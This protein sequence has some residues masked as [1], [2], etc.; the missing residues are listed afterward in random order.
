MTPPVGDG[1]RYDALAREGAEAVRTG[2]FARALEA[3]ASAAAEARRMSDCAR[4]DAADLNVAMALL[5]SG[6][7]RRAEDGLREILLRARTDQ[8]AF[9][10]AY[11]LASSLRK[12]GRY[13]RALDYA[14]RALD[15][16]R[17]LGG[18][19]YLAPAHNL[20]GNILLCRNA[21]DEAERS[22]LEALALREAQRSDTRF[23][24]A[25]LEDNLG[26]CM[27]LLKRVPEGLA[28][29]ER[30]LDLSDACGDRRCRAECLQD[31][32][33]GLLLADRNDE[34][35]ARGLDALDAATEDGYADLEENC[36]YL[37]GELGSRTGDVELR[38]RH[39][40]VLQ[41]RHPEIPFLHEFLCAVD[42]TGIITL[43]R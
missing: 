9:G 3:Y 12:Q 10:A 29:I 7:A 40:A 42:V 16:A 34:A 30:A 37:L 25:I 20:I 2:D 21:L 33:F 43:K 24:R 23:S 22:Y 31:L 17:S 28:R 5:Q 8:V 4:E 38:D 41:S 13:E 26:Y 14:R 18:P 27:I 39:F 15:R 11:N 32:C 36:R 35:I 6:E 19:D 1:D